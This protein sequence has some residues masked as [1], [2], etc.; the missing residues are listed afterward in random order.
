[1]APH[2]QWSVW[3]RRG[4]LWCWSLPQTC[5][6]PSSPGPCGRR[7]ADLYLSTSKLSTRLWRNLTQQQ[8]GYVRELSS[9]VVVGLAATYW[10]AHVRGGSALAKW[11]FKE[12][13]TRGHHPSLIQP[14][15]VGRAFWNWQTPTGSSLQDPFTDAP[16]FEVGPLSTP[17][18]KNSPLPLDPT[19]R[20][21]NGQKGLRDYC[22]H[23]GIRLQVEGSQTSTQSRYLTILKSCYL[24]IL[25]SCYLTI[26]LSCYL[27]ILLSQHLRSGWRVRDWAA[28]RKKMSR[29]RALNLMTSVGAASWVLI[30]AMINVIIL[31]TLRIISLRLKRLQKFSNDQSLTMKATPRCSCPAHSQAFSAPS[32]VILAWAEYFLHNC[33]ELQLCN[34][35]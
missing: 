8:A 11:N 26:L 16:W 17:I 13:S 5:S 22:V 34:Q 19:V 21:T 6:A 25:K 31:R 27:T 10:A 1:M 24:T 35:G 29:S 20:S 4:G 9:K 18:G 12:S 28:A 14:G 23:T 15:Q 32:W 2:I 30:L 7:N 3:C 33:G